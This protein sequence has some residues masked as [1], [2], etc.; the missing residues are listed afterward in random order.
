[1][2]DNYALVREAA[3]TGLTRLDKGAAT[4]VLEKAAKADA[5]PHVRQLAKELLAGKGRAASK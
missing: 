5:E 4:P 3:L 1:V 2:K